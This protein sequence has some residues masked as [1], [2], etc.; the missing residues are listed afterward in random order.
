M[1]AAILQWAGKEELRPERLEERKQKIAEELAECPG[2]EK[3]W[4]KKLGTFLVQSGIE[5]ISEMDYPLRSE[6]ESYLGVTPKWKN[7]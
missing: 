3:R 2:I 1:P 4:R 7:N 6:Y 5:H